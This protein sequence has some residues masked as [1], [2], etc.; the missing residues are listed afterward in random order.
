VLCANSQQEGLV[1]MLVEM[2]WH[3]QDEVLLP[4]ALWCPGPG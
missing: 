4:V 2:R 1:S 3:R